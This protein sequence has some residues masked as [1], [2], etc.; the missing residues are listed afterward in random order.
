MHTTLNNLQ[1]Q[2]VDTGSV[3][4]RSGLCAHVRSSGSS[5]LS[6]QRHCLPLPDIRRVQP[7]FGTDPPAPRHEQ[8]LRYLCDYVR[9]QQRARRR[10]CCGRRPRHCPLCLLFSLYQ[11]NHVH[12]DHARGA[13]GWDVLRLPP[14]AVTRLVRHV[15]A[16]SSTRLRL[17]LRLFWLLH[18]AGKLHDEPLWR[19]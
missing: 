4:A 1:P 13:R 8:P 10:R 12:A 15:V 9:G 11:L 14:T 2:P 7:H 19:C 5:G 6:E 16:E 17:F 18:A 3:W